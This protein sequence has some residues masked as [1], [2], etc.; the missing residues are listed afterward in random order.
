MEYTAEDTA[1]PLLT[2]PDDHARA[3]DL[4]LNQ[5]AMLHAPEMANAGVIPS[6]TGLWEGIQ[7]RLCA[8]SPANEDH[9]IAWSIWH[10]ARDRGHDHDVLAACA[11]NC[12]GRPTGSSECTRL[13]ATRQCHG[14]EQVITLSTSIDIQ[15]LRDYRLAVGR[16]TREVV[17]RLPA[18]A[19]GQKVLP[20]RLQQ[21]W[22]EGAVAEGARGL[23]DYWGGLTIAGLC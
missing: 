1:D 17:K 6:E 5:H 21:L 18:S 16:R 14:R 13:F 7:N 10:L 19:P 4:F 9:S 8:V 23:L 2:R 3:I 20:A 22:D 12:C 11:T 15:A